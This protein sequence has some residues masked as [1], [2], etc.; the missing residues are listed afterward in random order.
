MTS[1]TAN[2]FSHFLW[3]HQELLLTEPE[4]ISD[5]SRE[6]TNK[7]LAL[8]ADKKASEDSTVLDTL[9]FK[10]CYTF[11]SD[12]TKVQDQGVKSSEN[13]EARLKEFGVPITN[14][15]VCLVVFI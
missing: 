14:V 1:L 5:F 15:P 10:Y 6:L 9:K 4:D 13:W 7:L 3:C 11:W 12:V 8:R 2:L